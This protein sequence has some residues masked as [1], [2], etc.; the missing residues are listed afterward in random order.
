MYKI[1]KINNFPKNGFKIKTFP[2]FPK[3]G[4]IEKFP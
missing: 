1:S 2:Q 3:K 4:E